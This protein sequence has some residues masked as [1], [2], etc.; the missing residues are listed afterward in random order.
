MEHQNRLLRVADVAEILNC[1]PSEVYALKDRGEL[2]YCRIGGMVRFLPQ[3]V[4]EFIAGSLVE[5]DNKPRRRATM[6]NLKHLRL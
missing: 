2:P 3:A 6:P 4:E 1:S 5:R